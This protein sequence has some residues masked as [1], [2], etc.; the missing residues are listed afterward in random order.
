[1]DLTQEG[2][3]NYTLLEKQANKVLSDQ[4]TCYMPILQIL[5]KISQTSAVPACF[6]S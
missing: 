2:M 3:L 5:N 1:M 6:A 4:R